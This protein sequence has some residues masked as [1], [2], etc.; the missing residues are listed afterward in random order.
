MTIFRRY[1]RCL[2]LSMVPPST[3]VFTRPSTT[4]YLKKKR[5]MVKLM[6]ST[7]RSKRALNCANG[8]PS[9]FH[10]LGSVSVVLRLLGNYIPAAG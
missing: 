10:R 8:R 3:Q 5:L 1:Q 9:N 4:R 7:S 6:A 2:A